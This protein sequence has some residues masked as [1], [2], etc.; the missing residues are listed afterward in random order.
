MNKKAKSKNSNNVAASSNSNQDPLASDF[1]D[2]LLK[3]ALQ[4]LEKQLEVHVD[5]IEERA[6]KQIKK[7]K[8]DKAG[9]KVHTE[10]HISGRIDSFVF[11][12]L[13]Q[14]Y[15][16]E[17]TNSHLVLKDGGENKNFLEKMFSLFLENDPFSD[18]SNLEIF[19][20][21][22]NLKKFKKI[23]PE[24]YSIYETV[25]TSN[26]EEKGLVVKDDEVYL[27]TTAVRLTRYDHYSF[28]KEIMNSPNFSNPLRV[29]SSDN[30]IEIFT[31][32]KKSDEG[33]LDQ[34]L[35]LKQVDQ[36]E[37]FDDDGEFKYSPQQ[38]NLLNKFDRC[39][40]RFP[41][42]GLYPIAKSKQGSL[43]LDGFWPIDFFK[44]VLG[45]SSELYQGLYS[46][47]HNHY[48][49]KRDREIRVVFSNVSRCVF[50]INANL[51]YE[52]LMFL[53]C[54]LDEGMRN[55]EI[56]YGDDINLFNYIAYDG[57]LLAPEETVFRDKGI[58]INPTLRDG[59]DDLQPGFCALFID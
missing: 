5:D 19:N 12:A 23:C 35:E 18:K 8:K 17:F 22:I 13:K 30:F 53:R 45:D 36:D 26:F 7:S 1:L 52:K 9:S 41:S 34:F 49:Y 46:V 14:T 54:G 20:D 50:K 24:F 15:F 4:E 25:L 16:E 44:F 47:I 58:Q 51:D 56:N 48:Q 6:E 40:Y 10:I 21:S 27:K 29:F 28:L 32:R 39:G 2:A 43:Q 11:G 3:P 57:L 59:D 38:S 42:L 33:Q 37:D 31:A 55:S